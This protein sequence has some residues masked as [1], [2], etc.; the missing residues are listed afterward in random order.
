MAS[1]LITLFIVA[2]LPF[3]AKAPLVWA[4]HRA[5]GYD[6]HYPRQQQSRLTGFGQRCNA[7]HYNCF[8]A[9]AVYPTLRAIIH[10]ASSWQ[11][12]LPLAPVATTTNLLSQLAQDAAVFDAMQ[13]IHARAP[14]LLNRALLPQLA[15]SAT[16]DIIHLTDFVASVGSSKHQ[17]YAASKAALENL[18]LSL[19]RKLA[20]SIKVNAIAPALLMFNEGDDAAYREKAL[21]KSLMAIEPGPDEVW[22][23]ILYLLNSRYITGRILALDGGRHLNLP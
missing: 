18:T 19:S 7:A 6:N 13:H 17:A 23:S 2:L 12:D 14:Y 20:P 10:N 15:T 1:L 21:A 16:A 3:I 22:Q 4:M 9:L 5:G 8:E 11:A